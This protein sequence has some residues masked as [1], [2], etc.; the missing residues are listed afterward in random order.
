M[1]GALLAMNDKVQFVIFV[2]YREIAHVNDC[3]TN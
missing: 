3:A 1:N 2:T